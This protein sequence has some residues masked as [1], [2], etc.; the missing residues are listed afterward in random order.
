MGFL[1]SLLFV[2]DQMHQDQDTSEPTTGHD[3]YP[4]HAPTFDKKRG[5]QRSSNRSDA[6][7]CSNRRQN[8]C[9]LI[10]CEDVDHQAPENRDHEEIHDAEPPVEGGGEDAAIGGGLKPEIERDQVNNQEPEDAW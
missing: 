5:D 2:D 3:Q 7:A 10:G 1:Q 4:A 8:A 6:A 9:G